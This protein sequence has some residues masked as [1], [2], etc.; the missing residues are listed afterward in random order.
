MTN[1]NITVYVDGQPLVTPETAANF[2]GL[3]QALLTKNWTRARDLATPAKAVIA[4]ANG[5][6]AVNEA[7]ETVSYKGAALP[8]KLN[9]RILRMV[10]E[11]PSSKSWVNF[12]ERLQKNP[13][14]RSIESLYDFMAHSNIPITE[15]GL[16]MA[17]KA[18]RPDFKDV[19]S[20]TIDNTPGKTVS[21]PR[22][23]I[24]DD[25]RTPCHV[26]LHVGAHG[27]ASTFGGSD[28]VIVLCEIDPED[29]VCVP[30]DC[31]SEKMRCCKYTVIKGMKAGDPLMPSS[32]YVPDAPEKPSEVYTPAACGGDEED[33]GYDDG[34]DDGH[35]T[36]EGSD[37]DAIQTELEDL[38]ELNIGDLRKVAGRDYGIVGASKIPGGKLALLARIEETLRNPV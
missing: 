5:D 21:M 6:W 15:E 38:K 28:R 11:A 34:Y 4:W 25:P 13:S 2:A 29:V 31:N 27:Y 20:G 10:A 3:Q 32:V 30:Y 36:D 26:G 33:D 24:S 37:E 1:D 35:E 8:K 14:Y 9:E 18:V 23:Q 12:W 7:T 17:Y 22:N 16:I 19:H